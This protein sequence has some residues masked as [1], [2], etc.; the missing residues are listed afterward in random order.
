M[1]A[2]NFITLI[3]VSLMMLML[4]GCGTGDVTEVTNMIFSEET[5]F[6]S[7]DWGVPGYLV[8]KEETAPIMYEGDGRLMYWD[9]TFGYDSNITYCFTEQN[10]LNHGYVTIESDETKETTFK[11][12]ASE[13]ENLYGKP[14]EKKENHYRYLCSDNSTIY[15]SKDGV[16]VA[17]LYSQ[18]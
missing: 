9:K 1:K 11:N 15:L 5:G 10:K 16:N 14:Y 13:L 18:N 17:I 7:F 8:R 12:I 6:R 2:R 3:C 4:I